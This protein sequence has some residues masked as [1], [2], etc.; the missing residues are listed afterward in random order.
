MSP[1]TLFRRI[2]DYAHR[3]D[4]YPLYAELRANGVVRQEDGSYLVGTYDEVATLLDDP[5]LSSDP[6][7]RTGPDGPPPGADDPPPSFI[8]LDDP[9]HD[10]LRR[11]TLR[12]FGPPHSPG[13][14]DALHPGITAIAGELA[15]ALRGRDRIDIVDDFAYPLPVTVI[16]RLLGVPAGDVPRVRAWTTAMIAALDLPPGQ[17]PEPLRAAAPAARRELAE[18]LGALAETRRGEPAGDMLSALVNDDGPEGA[19]TGPELMS[20]AVLL[21]VAG[22]ETTVNLIANG[23]LTLLRHPDL[24]VR[25]RE[26]PE[27][28]PQAVEELLRYEP[29]VQFLPRRTPL[30]DIEVAGV[31]VPRGAPLV[32]VL[33]S[34]NRD[35]LRFPDPD[36]FDPMR[37]HNQHLGFGGGAHSCFGAPLARIGTQ[38]ALNALLPRLEGFRLAE[39]PPPYRRSPVV[40]GPRRLPVVRG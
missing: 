31:T 13:T 12:A 23:A 6:G 28:V 7:D 10:R 1:Q 3:A 5:R 27:L 17:D 40:R 8:D 35:P 36:R 25:L 37:E 39:D 14:V 16:C 11:L 22:H 18:Y 34:A 20:T 15:G 29:P 26:A 32:L 33:A 38:I 21:L 30:T 2:T 19:L 4:P 24:L 9:E